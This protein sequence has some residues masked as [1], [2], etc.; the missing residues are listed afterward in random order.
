MRK[1]RGRLF[2]GEQSVGKGSF[3]DIGF[4]E[5]PGQLRGPGLPSVF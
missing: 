1:D 5:V 3:G 4:Q 2:A